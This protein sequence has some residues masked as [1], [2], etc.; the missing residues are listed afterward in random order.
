MPVIEMD[1]IDL[2]I[3]EDCGAMTVNHSNNT[4]K[5][6]YGEKPSL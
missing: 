6:G 2:T 5:N 4:S 3:E 1:I